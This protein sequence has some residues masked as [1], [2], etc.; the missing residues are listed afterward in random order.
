MLHPNVKCPVQN[1]RGHRETR[2]LPVRKSAFPDE[3][4]YACVTTSQAPTPLSHALRRFSQG[5]RVRERSRFCLEV[6]RPRE[7]TRSHRTPPVPAP[8]GNP[9]GL[10]RILP[11][12]GRRPRSP[13]RGSPARPLSSQ[14]LAAGLS[15]EP[16]TTKA[17]LRNTAEPAAWRTGST[18]LHSN[19]HPYPSP[20]WLV[21]P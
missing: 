12:W 6:Q 17:S 14:L 9:H 19:W 16:G 7:P 5:N 10:P 2:A 21:R 3:E 18:R 1:F 4:S 8:P 20:E 11:A 13:W 15:T